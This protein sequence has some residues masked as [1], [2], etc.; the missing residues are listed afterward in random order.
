MLKSNN[1]ATNGQSIGINGG[2]QPQAN[3]QPNGPPNNGQ[4]QSGGQ[5][6]SQQPSNLN[7]QSNNSGP[8]S[9]PTSLPPHT[10][11]QHPPNSATPQ[12]PPETPENHTPPN[13]T[14][15]NSTNLSTQLSNNLSSNLIMG[16][17][18]SHQLGA[19]PHQFVHT[20]IQPHLQGNLGPNGGHLGHLGGGPLNGQQMMMHPHQQLAQQQQSYFKQQ[21]HSPPISSW[22]V[23]SAA[24]A[25]AINNSFVNQYPGSW[26]SHD[27]SSTL[28]T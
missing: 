24:K 11:I 2:P 27:P 9:S 18:P 10:P 20:Q 12:T 25:A 3:Q 13:L 14:L 16:L 8:G 28:L 17:P 5:P 23:N 1:A 6:C 22:D 19:Q 15:N 4:P 26:Y 7:P 21:I